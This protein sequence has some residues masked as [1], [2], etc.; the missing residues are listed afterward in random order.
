MEGS[1][2]ARSD[3][4]HV[5][6]G[7]PRPIT[8][9]DVADSVCMVVIRKGEQVIRLQPAPGSARQAVHNAVREVIRHLGIG[10]HEFLTNITIGASIDAPGP[11]PGGAQARIRKV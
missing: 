6:V 8:C 3:R 4:S 5:S 1:F 7:A 11:G 2:G 9:S 10:I